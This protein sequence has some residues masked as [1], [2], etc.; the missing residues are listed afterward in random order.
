M[1]SLSTTC[2]LTFFPTRIIWLRM[3]GMSVK[4]VRISD[5]SFFIRLRPKDSSA[6]GCSGCGARCRCS[7]AI[8]ARAGGVGPEIA[9]RREVL[10]PPSTSGC[11]VSVSNHIF[12]ADG[13]ALRGRSARC[14]SPWVERER[15]LTSQK[16]MVIVSMFMKT[17]RL[18]MTVAA[19]PATAQRRARSIRPIVPLLL[20][21]PP[22][23]A[24]MLVMG[25]VQGYAM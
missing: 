15:P 1:A 10:E 23:D 24:W 16:S 4:S 18:N 7:A 22:I 11:R 21:N 17:D 19:A 9:A 20:W 14:A 5:R 6:C 12:R 8:V 2:S 13:A 25:S 3:P